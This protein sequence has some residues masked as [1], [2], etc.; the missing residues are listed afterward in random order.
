MTDTSSGDAQEEGRVKEGGMLLCGQ[1]DLS[2]AICEPRPEGKEDGVM[3]RW[4]GLFR[5]VGQIKVKI[6][7]QSVHGM[8]QQGDVPQ[9]AVSKGRVE[10]GEVRKDS[11]GEITCFFVDFEEESG[12]LWSLLK[13][14]LNWFFKNPS[15]V[16]MCSFEGLGAG[17]CPQEQE[18]LAMK[19][20]ECCVPK[21]N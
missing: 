8:C 16:C 9:S 1:E 13:I 10:G 18:E 5:A 21:A 6:R 17:W 11:S 3:Q 12:F 4:W 2:V 7:G 20:R 19:G 15:Y 14:R